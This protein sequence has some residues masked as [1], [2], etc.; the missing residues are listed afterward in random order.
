MHLKSCKKRGTIAKLMFS[1]SVPILGGI[2]SAADVTGTEPL[3]TIQQEINK[4]KTDESAERRRV[5]QD[6]QSIRKL[7]NNSTNW[8]RGTR[9]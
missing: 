1:L 3:R 9:R 7:G 5:E 8:S 6:E 2:V 4:I